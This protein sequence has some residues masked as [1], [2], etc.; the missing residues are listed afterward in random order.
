MG[1]EMSQSGMFLQWRR[2]GLLLPAVVAVLFAQLAGAESGSEAVLYSFGRSATDGYIPSSALV[3][4]G[5]GSFYGTTSYGGANGGG[6]VFKITPS[7]AETVLYSFAASSSSDAIRMR[8]AAALIL[9]NDG[10]FYGTTTSGGANSK[11]AAFR[12][13]PSGVETTLYSF[14]A[15]S[16]D[17]S[18]PS[19]ALV[20]SSDGNFY[21]TT[22]SGGENGAGTV[23]SIT[24]SGVETVLYSFGGF[25]AD[26]LYPN[27]PLIQASDGNFYGTTTSGGADGQGT[28]FKITPAG[29]GEILLYS[30]GTSNADGTVP[31]GLL[32]G[33]DGNF[34][35]TTISGGEGGGGAVFK[36][37]PKGEESILYSFGSLSPDGITPN[38]LIQGGDGNFYG[39]TRQSTGTALGTVFQITPEGLETILYSFIGSDMDGSGPLSGLIEG[40]DGNL[41]GT[42]AY[43]GSNYHA[44]FTGTV[45]EIGLGPPNSGSSGG[46]SSGSGSSSGNGSSSS[47]SGTSSSGGSSSSGSSSSSSGSGSS[48]STSSSSSSSGSGSGSSSGGTGGSSSGS[49]SGGASS[50]G[51]SGSSSSSGSLSSSSS[52][53]GSSGASGNSSSSGSSSGGSTSSSSSSSSGAGSG[54]SSGGTGGASSS[55]NSS[56]SSSSGGGIAETGSS[57]SGGGASS[58]DVL[59]AMG[60]ALIGRKGRKRGAQSLAAW[61]RRSEK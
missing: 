3:Q 11:G 17:G 15:S 56:S 55:G 42:T 51:S 40:S 8:P 22:T 45:F 29:M 57:S 49:S 54:S 1:R 47:G 27:A 36:I 9:G 16:T 43:G 4:G 23:F 41:Y 18:E 39:T 20:Q 61:R 19:A 38:A 10:N 26:G 50:S 53:S 44:G 21:G 52:S 58:I 6:T 34:Y 7:G 30:F 35:G 14:G 60:L 2:L 32:Q 37:T 48:G 13:T 59:L 25:P 12:I 28:V 24:P 31:T 5:D 33:A 46:S